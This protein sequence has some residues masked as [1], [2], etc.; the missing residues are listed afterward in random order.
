MRVLLSQDLVFVSELLQL[1][2]LLLELMGLIVLL[3]QQFAE[4]RGVLHPLRLLLQVAL[5]SVY[6]VLLRA[7]RV[8]VLIGDALVLG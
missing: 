5:Q 6:L 8:L 2:Y 3:A 7:K 1:D 4:L